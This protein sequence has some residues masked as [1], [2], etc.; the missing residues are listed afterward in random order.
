MEKQGLG[1][2]L[3]YFILN[4]PLLFYVNATFTEVPKDV[5]V[6]EGEDIE[7]PCAF[8]AVGASPFSLEIQWWYLQEA[9]PRELAQEL[10]I[11]APANRPKVAPRDATKISTVRV[12]GNAISHKLSLSNVR[13]EDEGVYECRVSDLYSDETQEYKV[14]ATLRV[15][16]REGMV[17]E[18]AV[19]HIQNRWSLRNSNTAAGGRA[20]SE[21]GH[22]KSRVPPLGGIGPAPASVTT[23]ASAAKSSAS[24]RPGNASIL[25]QQHGAGSG[26]MAT[27]E[28]L[29]Y[30]TLLVLH[31]L[32]PFLIAN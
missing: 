9:A 27:T 22:G 3:Y 15:T 26:T 21:P 1:G 30:I 28:P 29:L 4:A 19:S 23:T 24:P 2:V 16:P 8:R 10:Q 13:K 11:S 17:A 5:T 32:I 14:Q 18:E 25:R 12:Q 31:K 20:T 7:M 6:G